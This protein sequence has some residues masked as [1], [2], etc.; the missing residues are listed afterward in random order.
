MSTADQMPELD[1]VQRQALAWVIRL[2]SGGATSDDAAALA[3]W[4]KRGP[5]YEDAFREAVQFWRTFG[6]ATRELV[7]RNEARAMPPVRSRPVLSRRLLIGGG[8]AAAASLGGIYVSKHPP[9]GLWPSIEELAADHRTGKGERR[10]IEVA[11][12]AVMTLNT[13]TAVSVRSASATPRVAL[14]SGEAAVDVS[15]DVGAM[16]I[17]AAGGRIEAQQASFNVRCVDQSVSVACFT[18]DVQV[19][20]EG[21]RA[22]LAA[23][24]QLTYSEESG[25]TAVAPADAEQATAW[26][27]GLLLVHDWPVDRLVAEINR[28]RPGRIVIMNSNL[29]RR[30]I[31]GTFYLDHLDDF[32]AQVHGL[33]GATARTLPGGI[34]LLS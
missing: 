32:V 13:Q 34:L 30:M 6:E 15:R 28:Y 11:K 19:E 7:G 10:K 3:L 17:D 21:R 29:G 9:L 33:F 22:V 1:A 2:N 4:R 18:G 8:V 14:I 31:S 25:L 20:W 27:R 24:Q 26:Q 12:N 16:V 5:E 23:S